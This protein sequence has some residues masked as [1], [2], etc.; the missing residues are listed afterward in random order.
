MVKEKLEKIPTPGCRLSDKRASEIIKKCRIEYSK[1]DK[2]AGKDLEYFI[3]VTKERSKD[4][5]N[6][7]KENRKDVSH[8]IHKWEKLPDQELGQIPVEELIKA[9]QEHYSDI[10][11][12]ERCPA[13]EAVRKLRKAEKEEQKKKK[14]SK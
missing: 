2:E 9:L 5:E 7:P 10:D 13:R 1:A 12:E 14:E 8:Y 4:P 6:E 11:P 3:V